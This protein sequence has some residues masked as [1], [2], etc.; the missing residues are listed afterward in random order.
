MK[1]LQ[2]YLAFFDIQISS[3]DRIEIDKIYIAEITIY[4]G[5]ENELYTPFIP[6]V[7]S[8]KLDVSYLMR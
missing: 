3:L 7:L 4:H 1:Q 2:S 5:K 6:A 8:V